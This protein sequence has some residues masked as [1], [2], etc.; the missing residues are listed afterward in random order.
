MGRQVYDRS[1]QAIMTEWLKSTLSAGRA[2]SRKEI[3]DHMAK[4]WPKLKS[5]TVACHIV[6]L[7]TNDPTRVHYGAGK[8]DDI[9]YR[10]TSGQYRLYRPETD[11]A[12]IYEKCAP[13]DEDLTED[14]VL[15]DAQQQEF[16]YE[17]DLRDFLAK[18]LDLIEPGLQLFE[19]EGVTGIEYPA[20]GRRIDILA[21]DAGGR[22]V[23]I[24]LKVSRGHER[25]VGQM[26][27]YLAWVRSNLSDGGPVRGIIVARQVSDELKMAVG[28]LPD[29]SIYRYDLKVTLT[30]EP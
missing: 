19:E 30:K 13:T 20:G 29:V 6:R 10:E 5:T 28:I 16:A 3:L 4:H 22:L 18:H 7:S 24:E 25:A 15:G 17:S 8:K 23:V 2:L 27:Y 21:E 14:T 11:P 9:L 1:C 26:A 12:P